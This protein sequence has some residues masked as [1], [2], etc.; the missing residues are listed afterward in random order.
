MVEYLIFMIEKCIMQRV[1]TDCFGVLGFYRI[2]A[3]ELNM[4]TG[5]SKYLNRLTKDELSYLLRF[6]EQEVVGS[7]KKAAL[8]EQAAD[9]IGFHPVDWLF[10]LPER[11]LLL[12]KKLTDAG[13]G[14]WIEMDMP[15]YPSVLEILKLVIVDDTIQDMPVTVSIDESIYMPV[16]MFVDKVIADKEENGDFL[17]ERIILGILNLYGVIPSREFIENIFGL[18]GDGEEARMK[19]EMLLDSRTTAIQTVFHKGEAYL[20]S[21]YAVNFEHILDARKKFKEIKDYPVFTLRAAIEAGASAPF[22][23]ACSESPEYKALYSILE[24]LGY[25]DDEIRE[26]ISDIWFNS[27]FAMDEEFTTAVFRCVND[28]IDNIDSFQVFRRYIDIVAAYANSVPKWLLKG[29]TSDDVNFLKLSIKI[30]ETASEARELWDS[31]KEEETGAVDSPN[32]LQEFYKYNMAVQHVAPDDP[33]PCG[34]GLSYCRCH[35]K[36]LN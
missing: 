23:A 11:D 10:L 8:V 14:K 7:P 4:N 17:K 24:H 28:N 6:F 3:A 27:Q 26:E 36:N 20:V 5:L 2:F 12:L 33:C 9:F 34:S 25:E 1:L 16:C 35:G 32:P 30:E 18:F 31:I 22:C 21:P 29:Y 13:P 15:D 19:A